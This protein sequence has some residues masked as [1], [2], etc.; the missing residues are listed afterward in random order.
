MKKIA[1]TLALLALCS[2]SAFAAN[3]V[4]ISQVYGGGGSAAGSTATYQQDYVELFNNSGVAVNIGGWAIEYG[5]P[6]GNWGSSAANIFNFPVGA[7]I[8]PC[9]YVLVSFGAATGGGGPL[10]VAADYNGTL[11][12]G[13]AAGKVALFTSTQANLACSGSVSGGAYVDAVGF[14]ST[15]LCYETS[16]APGLTNQ[17]ADVRGGAGTQDTDANAADF[18]A[19]LNPVPRNSQSP[20]NTAC[21]ATPVSNGSWGHVKSLYR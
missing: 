2:T 13:A 21:L 9:S 12:I 7:S 10:P 4:R 5:S 19:V 20:A 16:P 18:T 15:A 8:A 3:A 17:Q 6:T 14:G 1:T 11:T